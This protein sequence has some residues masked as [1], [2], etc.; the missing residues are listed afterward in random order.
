[1]ASTLNASTTLGLI[2][3]ADTS[4]VLQ[5]QTA[6]TAALTI[7]G[8]Q[9]VGIGTASP[10]AKLDVNSGSAIA[11][12]L[13]RGGG[14]V[15]NLSQ[16][17]FDGT[18][19]WYAGVSG[20]N[21]FGIAYNSSGG[22][23]DSAALRLDTSGNL[24]LGVTPSTWQSVRR[25]L[26]VGGNIALWGQSSGAGSLFL[27]NNTYFDG[28]NFRYLNTSGAGYYAQATDG[29]HAWNIAASGTA[30]NAITF[31]QAMTLDASGRFLL[32]ATSI[33]A[34]FANSR[35]YLDQSVADYSATLASSSSTAGNNYGILIKYLNAT[36]NGTGNEF[37]TC[38]DSTNIKAALRSNGGLANYSANNV[39]LSDARTKTDIQNSGNYLAKICAIPVRTFKYKDQT[40]DFLNLGCIAQEVEAVAP[41]LVDASGFGETPE[42]GVPLKAIYQTD[43]QYALMK[44]IQEQQAIIESLK[45]RLDAANI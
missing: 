14:I 24:G 42:D 31:T 41:E 25:V 34:S 29:A 2:S 7:D 44:C 30:G 19:S 22:A 6:N 11:V 33:P 23:I 5:L 9:N 26:Q 35:F 8:S 15:G 45:A 38:A 27:S 4:G 17:W 12:R 28:T 1:M 16:Q 20:S 37:L 13:T 36:P 21:F 18:N 10:A 43:L 40:D 39:N 32:G 3:S